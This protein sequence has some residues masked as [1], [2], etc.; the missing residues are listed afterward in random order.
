MAEELFD[1]VDK[2]DNVI[3]QATYADA[4][5]NGKIIRVVHNWI[6]NDEGKVLFQLRAAHKVS[7]P[8]HF[9]CSVGGKVDAGETYEKA[10]V[11][12]TKEEMGVDVSPTFVGK[13]YVDRPKEYKFISVNFSEYNGVVTGWEEEAEVIEWMT[14]DEANQMIKRFP[15]LFCAHK[16]FEMF[17]EYAK[18]NGLVK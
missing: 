8:R 14:F 15:Y 7:M 2:D 5:E 16:S 17:Y 18:E 1:V 12:E 11:R 9:D 10:V 13:Y 6:I 3:E 4:R